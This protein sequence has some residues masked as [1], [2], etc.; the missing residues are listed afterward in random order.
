MTIP[1]LRRKYTHQDTVVGNTNG[2]CSPPH[3]SL[4]HH[5]VAWVACSSLTV[6]ENQIRKIYCSNSIHSNLSNRRQLLKCHSTF[7]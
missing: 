5:D 3:C 7:A 2:V 6:A 4:Y 1:V